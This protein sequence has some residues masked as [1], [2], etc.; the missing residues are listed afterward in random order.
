MSSS[1]LLL[2]T[3]VQT[4]LCATIGAA[5]SPTTFRPRKTATLLLQ[6]EHQVW[7]ITN[8]LGSVAIA[9]EAPPERGR[10]SPLP[11]RS[12]TEE[13]VLWSE[14]QLIAVRA[15]PVGAQESHWQKMHPDPEC[16]KGGKEAPR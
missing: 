4:L 13:P 1:F 8:W 3:F 11:A 15:A 14:S 5:R 16:G 9:A 7:N 2:L 10:G 12:S 6:K